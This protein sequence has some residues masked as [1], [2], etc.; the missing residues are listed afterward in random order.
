[1]EPDPAEYLL[2]A[3]R[4][5]DPEGKGFIERDIMKNLL[6]TM[7]INFREEEYNDFEAFALDKSGNW[8]YFEDY[9]AKLMEANE[10]QHEYL[11]KDYPNFKAPMTQQ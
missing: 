10:Q 4:V 7:G 3:F 1:M 11:I 6:M 8:F 9:V 2:A 5:L